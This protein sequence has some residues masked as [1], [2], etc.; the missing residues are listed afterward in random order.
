MSVANIVAPAGVV[1]GACLA[2]MAA[3]WSARHTA[4]TNR[5]IA[6]EERQ[7]KAVDGLLEAA[8]EVESSLANAKFDVTPYRGFRLAYHRFVAASPRPLLLATAEALEKDMRLLEKTLRLLDRA[9]VAFDEEW[10]R[11]CSEPSIVDGRYGFEQTEVTWSYLAA[12]DSRRADREDDIGEQIRAQAELERTLEACGEVDWDTVDS[13]M[14]RLDE[15]GALKVQRERIKGRLE[16]AYGKLSA[17][18]NVP[19]DELRKL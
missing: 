14:R 13:L 18:A 1:I 12:M 6:R 15:L 7:Y 5:L 17:A 10:T 3:L 9:E 16:G 8:T 19:A 4:H 2:A 11:A